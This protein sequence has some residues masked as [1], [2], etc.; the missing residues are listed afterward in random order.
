LTLRAT[1]FLK[2]ESV[3]TKTKKACVR[4]DAVVFDP[5]PSF[6][7]KM[8]ARA[9][10]GRKKVEIGVVA[11]SARRN[12]RAHS[13]GPVARFNRIR[14]EGLMRRNNPEPATSDR[15][16]RIVQPIESCARDRS[17]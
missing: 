5:V 2:S 16:E 1:I 11:S 4:F 3:N 17:G 8:R 6:S 12:K 7:A 14:S 15:R 9:A 13:K 10:Q